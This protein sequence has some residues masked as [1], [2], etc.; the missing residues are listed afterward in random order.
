[1]L[2]S[3]SDLLEIDAARQETTKS[4]AS[5]SWPP[6]SAN[7]ESSSL[8]EFGESPML[9]QPAVASSFA[10]TSNWI[11]GR[12]LHKKAN[13]EVPTG[14][15]VIRK[16]GADTY[17]LNDGTDAGA[18]CCQCGAYV[19]SGYDTIEWSLS[20]TC[21]TV[22]EEVFE[23]EPL[24]LV[25]TVGK[26][27]QA[28]GK[29]DSAKAAECRRTCRGLFTKFADQ[30]F[31]HTRLDCIGPGCKLVVN[32]RERN[33]RIAEAKADA[34]THAS[35]ADWYA[36]RDAQCKIWQEERHCDTQSWH[37]FMLTAC[38]HQC[39]LDGDLP[40]DNNSQGPPHHGDGGDYGYSGGVTHDVVQDM[41]NY[42]EGASQEVI[43]DESQQITGCGY[44]QKGFAVVIVLSVT[45]LPFVLSAM[46][47]TLPMLNKEVIDSSGSGSED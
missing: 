6:S 32:W 14:V 7:T 19:L 43:Y 46:L 2:R 17:I 20:G 16:P 26:E 9:I 10:T 45:V 21:N 39:E 22:C 34:A 33:A 11:W 42:P 23:T 36:N 8:S 29:V 27:C 13:S 25:L 15:R 38:K 12:K 44:D 3:G 5:D 1:M 31:Q 30:M 40:L 37:W 35:K 47:G 28:K 4:H 24:D 41:V 18:V